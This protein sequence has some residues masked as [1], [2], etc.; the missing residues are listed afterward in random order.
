[1]F[2]ANHTEKIAIELVTRDYFQGYLNAEPETLLKAFH[3]GSRLFCTDQ[4]NLETTEMAEWLQSLVERRKKGDRRQANVSIDGIDISSD[5]AVVKTTLILK[6]VRFTDY[7]SLLKLNG[8][9]Q[10]VNKIYT[11]QNFEGDTK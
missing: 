4:G 1:M 5:A 8:K 10:I 7:L 6:T 11:V 9:W 2:D 3:S